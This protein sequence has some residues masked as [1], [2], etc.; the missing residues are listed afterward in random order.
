MSKGNTS[1]AGEKKKINSLPVKII[2][3]LLAVLVLVTGVAY[4]VFH[5]FY[6]KLNTAGTMDE[7][8]VRE[9]IEAFKASEAERDAEEGWR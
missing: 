7:A 8:E 9:N 1:R 5:Y 2:L 3:V 4:G 6:S